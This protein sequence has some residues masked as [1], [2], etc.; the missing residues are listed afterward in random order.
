MKTRSMLL[1]MI[2]L[3]TLVLA[4]AACGGSTATTT[5][6][7]ATTPTA[8]ISSSN[9]VTSSKPAP[10]TTTTTKTSNAALSE[11]A[12]KI[13]THNA[14]Q[15]TGYKGLCLM[16]HGTGTTNAF[17]AAP[18]WDGKANGSTANPGTYT[19]TA[20]SNADHTG[21]TADDCTKAGCHTS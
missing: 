17:P 12:A 1:V 2:S 3:L 7:P 20:G 11:T 19:V 15:L 18:S 21:R 4:V 8:P 10:T 13:T 5:S 14:A 9:T 16:C 6:K